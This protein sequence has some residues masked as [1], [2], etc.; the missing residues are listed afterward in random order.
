[1]DVNLPSCS[2]LDVL[3]K[4]KSLVWGVL[5]W[6]MFQFGSNYIR[7]CQDNNMKNGEWW[8]DNGHNMVVNKTMET[9]M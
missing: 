2:Y 5:I 7:K 6:D 3:V 8:R 1:M 4:K 9:M